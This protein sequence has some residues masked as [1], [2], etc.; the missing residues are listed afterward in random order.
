MFRRALAVAIVLACTRAPAARAADAVP[1]SGEWQGRTIS[2]TF[3]DATT[4]MVVAMGPGQATQL[5]RFVMTS[6]P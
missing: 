1:F 5:G 4:V 2:A 6:P 3:V